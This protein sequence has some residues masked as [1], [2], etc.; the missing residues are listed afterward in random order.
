MVAIVFLNELWTFYLFFSSPIF[1]SVGWWQERWRATLK[2][3]SKAV[4]LKKARSPIRKGCYRVFL[5]ELWTYIWS[6]KRCASHGLRHATG[7]ISSSSRLT[8][9]TTTNRVF[10]PISLSPSQISFLKSQIDWF[11]H[12][13]VRTASRGLTSCPKQ[14]QLVDTFEL[15]ITER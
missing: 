13:P 4:R 2:D 10:K 6:S 3:E 11:A 14:H 12:L 9:P 8:H 1:S 7:D 5:N 15:G